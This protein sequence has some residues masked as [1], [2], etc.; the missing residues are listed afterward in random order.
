LPAYL[1]IFGNEIQTADSHP[2]LHAIFRNAFL[3]GSFQAR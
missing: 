2:V 3:Y 1:V